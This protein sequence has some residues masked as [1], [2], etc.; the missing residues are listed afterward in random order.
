MPT[1]EVRIAASGDDGFVDDLGVFNSTGFQVRAGEFGTPDRRH[2]SW[3]RFNGVTIPRGSTIDDAYITVIPWSA[4]AGPGTKSNIHLEAA[5][6]VTSAPVSKADMD[7]R[8]RTTAFSAWDDAVFAGGIPINS[9]SIATAVKEVTDRAGWNSGQSVMVLWDDDNSDDD[10]IYRGTAWDSD[11]T[12]AVL[13]HIEYTACFRGISATRP[14]GSPFV[15]ATDL[16]LAYDME[17]LDGGLMNDFGP[18]G[19][20]GTITGAND[21]AGKFGRARNFDGIDDKFDVDDLISTLA[22]DT[23]GTIAFWVNLDVD[24][25]AEGVAFAVSRDSGATRSDLF[26]SFDWTLTWN[27][28]YLSV[29]KDGSQVLRH[30]TPDGSLTPFIGSWLHV[31]YRQKADGTG[32]EIFFNGVSQTITKLVDTDGDAWFDEII[33]QATNKADSGNLGLIELDGSDLAPID[34]QIDEFL[35]FGRVLTDTEIECL[36]DIIPGAGGAIAWIQDD[37]G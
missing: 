36:A 7:S 24:T 32:I 14:T 11:T 1:I 6:D 5:D 34:A 19:S 3:L 17:T 26:I 10:K 22:T 13:L 30:D 33:T 28:T 9:P 25:G 31:A 20:D 12:K 23:V 37:M 27:R 35:I 8:V 2:D 29:F 18:D 16:R 4:T 15:S 21:V